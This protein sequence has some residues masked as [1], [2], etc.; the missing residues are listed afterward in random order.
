MSAQRFEVGQ[1]VIRTSGGLRSYER[2]ETVRRALKRFVE[3]EDGSRWTHAGRV[4]PKSAESDYNPPR[5]K[6]A[7]PERLADL[8]DW[9]AR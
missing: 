4:Y 6:H 3:L 7:S 2:I 9:G 1:K 5:I 8:Q